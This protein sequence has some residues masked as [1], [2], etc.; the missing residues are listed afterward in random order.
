MEPIETEIYSR[1]EG[2]ESQITD[3][4]EKGTYMSFSS[5]ECA[6]MRL[7]ELEKTLGVIQLL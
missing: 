5:I 7:K 2:L 1:I 4:I 3:Y 6:F